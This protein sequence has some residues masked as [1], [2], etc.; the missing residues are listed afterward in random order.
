M[1]IVRLGSSTDSP[2]LG[3]VDGPRVWSFEAAHT[4]LADLLR[5]TA[6][7]LRARVEA[8]SRTEASRAPSDTFLA[9]IDGQTE[10]WA[11]GVTYQRSEEARAAVLER[12]SREVPLVPLMYGPTVVAHAWRVKNFEPSP[13]GLPSL[14]TVDVE[15]A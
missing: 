7:E 4:S 12:V 15:G 5:L 2:R 9:P 14:A 1:Q 13:L 8:V 6:D 10:V 3:L 11:A